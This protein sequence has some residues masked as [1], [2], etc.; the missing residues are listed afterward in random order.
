M[1]SLEQVRDSLPE[2]F[3]FYE[4][5][6]I[7]KRQSFL[8]PAIDF[9]E[10][11]WVGFQIQMEE[12]GFL[13][14]LSFDQNRDHSLY[15][16]VG[17]TIVSQVATNLG[18]SAEILS[19]SPPLYPSRHRIEFLTQ[20]YPYWKTHYHHQLELGWSVIETLIFKVQTQETLD[21]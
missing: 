9:S 11:N 20:N 2:K 13:I 21:V 15:T 5:G 3:H 10:K 8:S 1:F 14:I 6:L 18:K 19:L 17:N 7:E 16:E 12:E 4:E